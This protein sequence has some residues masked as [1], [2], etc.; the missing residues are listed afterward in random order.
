MVEQWIKDLI[1]NK[2][3][4]SFLQYMYFNREITF[5]RGKIFGLWEARADPSESRDLY[6][7]RHLEEFQFNTLKSK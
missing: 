1:L 7:E 3:N 5:S 6:L 2:Y 4:F